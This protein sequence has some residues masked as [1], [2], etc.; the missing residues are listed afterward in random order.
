MFSLFR[1][2]VFVMV[3]M[4][5]FQMIPALHYKCKNMTYLDFFFLLT[6][7]Q[8]SSLVRTYSR[9]WRPARCSKIPVNNISK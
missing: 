5:E 8:G 3:R 2:L 1:I 9:L 6:Y 7:K 4:H